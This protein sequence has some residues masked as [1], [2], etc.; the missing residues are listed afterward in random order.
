MI[1]YRRDIYMERNK[2]LL[3]NPDSSRNFFCNVRTYNT[4]EKP[5]IWDIK[6]LCPDLSDDQ[7]ALELSH[8]FS[9]VSNEFLPFRSC[10]IPKTFDRML[11]HLQPYQVAGRI[12][13]IK[14]PR[15]KIQGDIFPTLA[16]EYA[17]LLALPLC[18][19]Y[20][21]ITRSLKWP[22]VWK[23]EIVTVIPKCSDPKPFNQLRNISCTLLVSKIYESYLLSWIKDEAKKPV[24]RRTG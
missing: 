21:E 5:K 1:K 10:Q 14:R 11:P 23:L 3:V 22:V 9:T 18:N 19:I 15:T 7:L 16:T 8:Y 20:K 2:L 13:S 17:E 4:V 24:R 6:G 12:R